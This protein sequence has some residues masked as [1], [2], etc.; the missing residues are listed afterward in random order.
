MS[1]WFIEHDEDGFEIL[2]DGRAFDWGF[3]SID[4]ALMAIRR[5]KHYSP[6]DKVQATDERGNPVRIRP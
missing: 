1:K 5:S 2:R 4:T 3:A 6:G